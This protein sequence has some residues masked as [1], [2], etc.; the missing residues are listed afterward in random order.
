[1]NSRDL[2]IAMITCC[3][4]VVIVS[5]L[6]LGLDKIIVK[7]LMPRPSHDIEISAI[8]KSQ[9]SEIIPIEES[10][11]V[12]P[13]Q[14]IQYV[15]KQSRDVLLQKKMNAAEND[16]SSK[17]KQ[18]EKSVFTFYGTGTFSPASQSMQ[19]QSSLSLTLKPVIGTS[20]SKFEIQSGRI[21]LDKLGITIEQGNLSFEKN[22]EVVLTFLTS[23]DSKTK[24]SVT[25]KYQETILS[26][27]DKKINIT[28][29]KQPL[30]LSPK[31]RASS[32]FNIN[33]DITYP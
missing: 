25:G 33:G 22:N 17:I 32:I 24:I 19:K 1:M 27:T 30:Q 18:L 20:L 15:P 29:T 12:K 2:H 9:V 26:D 7:P 16:Y 11:P 10:E 23:Y 6:A 8:T 13:S 31:M 21:I 4:A 3:I 14:V 28:F 5:F